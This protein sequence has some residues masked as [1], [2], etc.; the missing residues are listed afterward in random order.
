VHL[1]SHA[2]GRATTAEEH[3]PAK[4]RHVASWTPERIAAWASKTGP[5]TA[6]LCR[7]IMAARP[8]PE[9]GFRSCLGVLRLG[10]RYGPERLEA[11]CSRAHAMGGNSCRSVRSILE[12]GLDRTAQPDTVTTPAL[13]H[14]NVR[15]ADYYD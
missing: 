6:A 3:M 12:R 2:R 1:R 13:M 4:H 15:G 8:H 11:A 9:L 10:E 5:E 7:A 14:V